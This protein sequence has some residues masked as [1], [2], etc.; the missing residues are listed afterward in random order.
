MSGLL[1]RGFTT[2]TTQ[3]A[4]ARQ[5]AGG[6]LKRIYIPRATYIVAVVGTGLIN[7]LVSILPVL[8]ILVFQ[9]PFSASWLFLPFSITILTVFTLGLRAVASH[10]LGFFFTDSSRFIRSWSRPVSS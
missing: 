6:L 7:F 4:M 2:S 8:I 9:H 5:L 10:R 3:Y 1:A